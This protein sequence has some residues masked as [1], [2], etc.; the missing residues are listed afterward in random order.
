[1]TEPISWSTIEAGLYAWLTGITPTV[2]FSNQRTPQPAYPYCSVYLIASAKEGG[3]DEL[4]TA[5]Q[6]TTAK[7]VRVT[8]TVQNTAAYTITLN[9]TAYTYTSDSSATAAEITAGLKAIVTATGFTV[10][11]NHGTLDIS[12]ATTFAI[13]VTSNLAWANLD[14]GHDVSMV[15][16]GPRKL[17][18]QIT[19]HTDETSLRAGGFDSS[20]QALAESC[21]SSLS[22]QSVIDALY[23]AGLAIVRDQGIKSLDLVVNGE[24]LSRASVDVQFRAAAQMTE[25]TGYINSVEVMLNDDLVVN[26]DFD[27]WVGGNLT[28]WSKN[29]GGADA[30]VTQVGSGQTVGG[31]GTGSVCLNTATSVVLLFQNISVVLGTKYKVKLTISAVSGALYFG[32]LLNSNF[33]HIYTTVGEKTFTFTANAASI[34]PGLSNLGPGSA[35]GATVDSMEIFEIFV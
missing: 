7:S 29:A 9:G 24:W 15:T 17:T 34:R 27:T 21:V 2:I 18:Y 5:D 26:G 28:G 33:S 32:D 16:T 25:D 23:A 20:A 31:T 12:K 11:D 1:M 35:M 14:A 10:T 22:K 19:F 4:I 13:V 6:L 8:P 3:R 30:T